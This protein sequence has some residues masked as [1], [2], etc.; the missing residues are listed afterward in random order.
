MV[1]VMQVGVWVCACGSV[2]PMRVCCCRCHTRHTVSFVSKDTQL[3]GS[4][5]HLEV[6]GFEGGQLRWHLS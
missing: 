4:C 1:C 3:P 2:I 6:G 5:V